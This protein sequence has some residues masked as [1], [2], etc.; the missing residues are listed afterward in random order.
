MLQFG[1]YAALQVPA[2]ALVDRFGPRRTL[3]AAG[4]LTGT[5]QLLFGLSRDFPAGVATRV[6]LGCGDALTFVSVLRVAANTV[7]RKR[8][9][10]LVAVA[11]LVGIAGNL[12]ATL[13]LLV[14]LRTAGWELTFIGLA[15]ATFAVALAIHVVQREGPSQRAS[16][17]RV[18]LART[19]VRAWRQPETRLGF[20]LHF[21]CLTTAMTL[22]VLWGYPYLTRGAGMAEAAAGSVMFAGVLLSGAAMPVAGWWFTSRPDRR[23]STAVAVAGGTAALW[24]SVLALGGAAPKALVAG[25]FIVSMVGVPASTACYAIVRDA[26]DGAVVST[27]T[28]VVNIGGYLATVLACL[29]VGL[30][31]Q[32]SGHQSPGDFRGALVAMVLVQVVGVIRIGVWSRRTHLSHAVSQPALV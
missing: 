20:W 30:M 27:A 10:T 22:L 15:A 24:G 19:A 3:V 6:V 4:I 8:Y 23:V 7:D 17:P 9:P 18:G 16:Q 26:V 13:P 29:G 11:G 25:V 12:A 32:L 31:L 5:A 1:I 21:S 2:G 14:V 28:G